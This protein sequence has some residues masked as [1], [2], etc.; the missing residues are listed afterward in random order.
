MY[1]PVKIELINFLSF[2]H[3]IFEFRQGRAVLIVGN[4]L[5][6][7]GQKGNGSGKSS[8]NEGISLAITGSSIRDVKARELVRDEQESGKV[9]FFLKNTKTNEIFEIHREV[10]QKETKSSTCSLFENDVEVTTCSD[11]NAYNKYILNKIGISKEDF[12][13]FF[14]I[15]KEQ[16][17]PFLSIGDTKKKEIINRF[18]GADKVDKVDQFI[19][20]DSKAKQTEIDT[21]NTSLASNQ[22]KQILLLEQIDIE[23]AS[24][25]EIERQKKIEV[26]LQKIDTYERQKI[27]NNVWSKTD[28][29][30]ISICK[31]N[32]IRVE[33]EKTILQDKLDILSTEDKQLETENK[34]KSEESKNVVTKYQ[35]EIDETKSLDTTCNS[36]IKSGEDRIKFFSTSITELEHQLEGIITCPECSHEFTLQGE[37]FDI[38]YA[39]ERLGEL[40]GLVE[41]EKG[42]IDETNQILIGVEKTKLDINTKI[43]KDRESILK[44]LGEISTR[45][46][47]ISESQ[48]DLKKD[49]ESLQ[50]EIN[51][52]NS[53]I[54]SYQSTIDGRTKKNLEHD[55]SIKE[56]NDEIKVLQSPDNSKL[57]E[58]T[59]SLETVLIEE[60]KLT[61]QSQKLIE[62][63]QKI[64]EWY[65]NFKSFK[66]FLANQSIKDITDYTN[67]FL[68]SMNSNISI[69]IE[70]YKILSNK[71]LKEEITTLV[72]KDGFER[73]SYGKLSAGERGRIELACILGMQNL[74]NLN[75]PTGGL[76]LLICDEILDS[77]DSL[78]LENIIGSLQGIDSTIM[79][80]SQ[81]DINSLKENTIIVQKEQGVSTIFGY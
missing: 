57:V 25:T 53:N 69:Q 71:K 1:I 26:L 14:L 11:I 34:T 38:N 77:V 75:C 36:T 3:Q 43:E 63:K 79:I 51:T 30:N 44:R 46:V 35:K 55:V 47:K 7:K 6:D 70:G 81:N 62:E 49:I 31:S 68:A 29:E 66:S 80:V 39:K 64:D 23:E 2:T 28:T 60:E 52:L 16:Y 48:T 10:F 13:N 59:N 72:Y 61:L 56:C 12:Y 18:S 19:D 40:K 27:Q 67:F 41:D 58:L 33:G 15:T 9:S 73:G 32:I 65:G 5:D 78:G 24:N 54:T 20:L 74:I 17:T 50:Q 37:D 42:V 21:V 8:I 4:N 76:D 22:G 45:R